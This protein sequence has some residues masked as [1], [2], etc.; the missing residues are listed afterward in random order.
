MATGIRDHYGRGIAISGLTR[1]TCGAPC[2]ASG[3]LDGA[4]IGLINTVVRYAVNHGFHAI[5]KGILY[6]GHY[7]EMITG[8]READRGISFCYYFEVPFEE[9]MLRY[10]TKPKASTAARR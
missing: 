10:V 1:T 8:L 6:S 5:V 7:A 3:T 4:N 9:T 2:S